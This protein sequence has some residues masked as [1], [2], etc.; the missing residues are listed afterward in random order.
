MESNNTDLSLPGYFAQYYVCEIHSYFF[1]M[2][3][4]FILVTLCI[5]LLE[6]HTIYL[7]ILLLM[8]IWVRS[9]FLAITDIVAVTYLLKSFGYY[10]HISAAYVPRRRLVHMICKC[11]ALMA[12]ATHFFEAVATMY[13]L[14]SCAREWLYILPN[15]RCC[16]APFNSFFIYAAQ[17]THLPLYWDSFQL[18]TSPSLPAPLQ[19][20]L[21]S[22]PALVNIYIKTKPTLVFQVLP[23]IYYQ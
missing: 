14:S 22:I 17:L 5:S 9:N 21:S 7:S 10:L 23:Y 13:T 3:Y 16:R 11:S 19:P 20:Q 12:M 4:I 8:D 1:H 2:V 15:T 6:Y 18:P